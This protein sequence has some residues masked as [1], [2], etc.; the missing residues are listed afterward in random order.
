[1][2][3]TT[4]LPGGVPVHTTLPASSLMLC[5][6]L[7]VRR[8]MI[9]LVMRIHLQESSSAAHGQTDVQGLSSTQQGGGGWRG[10]GWRPEH[11]GCMLQTWTKSRVR[12]SKI[13]AASSVHPTI[14]VSTCSLC[15]LKIRNYGCFNC[16]SKKSGLF[17]SDRG[18]HY[19]E[20]QTTPR[21]CLLYFIDIH[22]STSSRDDAFC[23]ETL[24]VKH[25]L[26]CLPLA[27]ARVTRRNQARMAQVW[28]YYR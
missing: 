14:C 20:A 3:N 18:G 7:V 4:L 2:G 19:K 27:V 12:S 16:S 5:N 13:F 1:M 9:C 24:L 25:V 15:K 21:D 17:E 26:D 10:A 8:L 6:S 22:Q 11:P 23:E 28:K